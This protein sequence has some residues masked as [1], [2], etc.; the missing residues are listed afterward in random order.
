M[1]LKR[2]FSVILSAVISA[3]VMTS[4]VC[5]AAVKGDVTGD[6]VVNVRDAAY[7]A[8]ALAKGNSID[9]IGDY[10]GD[11]TV[12]IRDAAAIAKML[13][14]AFASQS[15]A[16][17]MLRLVNIER[18]KVGVAPLVL[19]STMNDAANV[20]A[21]EITTYFSHTRPDG[22]S[23]FTVFDEFNISYGWCGENIAAGNS[24]VAATMDQWINSPG[25]YENMISPNY[26]ELGVGN[27]GV[28]WVQLFKS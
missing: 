13:G 18:E 28:Y 16:E 27:N 12:N 5:F 8:T 9:S 2:C 22:T 21:K 14:S 19:N 26:T 23:C 1:K 10:N 11:G 25:H 17:E 20:R 24:T 6:G 7:I 4:N 3:A 15:I